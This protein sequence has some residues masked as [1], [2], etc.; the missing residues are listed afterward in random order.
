[1]RERRDARR[2]RWVFIAAVSLWSIVGSSI[3]HAQDIACDRPGAKEVR[4]LHF[5]GNTTFKDDELS[6]RVVTTA[7]SFM[8]RYFRW[9][10]NAGAARCVPEN[11]LGDDVT[12]LKT[13]YKNNGFYQTKVDTKVTPVPRPSRRHVHHRRRP[14]DSGRIVP[15][16]RTRFRPGLRGDR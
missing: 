8:H 9:L 11:G 16:H 13:F 5:Q 12:L 4:A 7:S 1:M 6:A 2:M 14:A 3:A 15:H 10:F